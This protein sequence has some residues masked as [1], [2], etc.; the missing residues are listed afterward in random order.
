MKRIQVHGKYWNH[1]KWS[2]VYLSTAIVYT[3]FSSISKLYLLHKWHKHLDVYNWMFWNWNDMVRQ[4][5]IKYLHYLEYLYLYFICVSVS[6]SALIK[7]H[8]YIL[9]ECCHFLLWVDTIY[10]S[11]IHIERHHLCNKH[12]YF[13]QDIF[14]KDQ[15]SNDS[16]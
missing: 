1:K 15:T 14:P 11:D 2:N 4:Q 9:F 6:V 16:L 12:I 7:S 8:L 3:L 5:L 10:V 13:F